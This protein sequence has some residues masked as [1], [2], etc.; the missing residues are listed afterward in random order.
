MLTKFYITCILNYFHYTFLLIFETIFLYSILGMNLFGCKFRKM[1][2]VE[3][4]GRKQEVMVFAR[5]NFDS[6]LWA[7][8]TVF[9]VCNRNQNLILHFLKIK[10]ILQDN[11]PNCTCHVCTFIRF[12]RVLTIDF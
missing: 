3:I 7:T 9:Q 11:V 8:V 1:E 5:K 4:N 12:P 2:E 10:I 6:L